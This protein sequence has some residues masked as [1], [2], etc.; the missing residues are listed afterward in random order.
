MQTWKSSALGTQIDGW[1]LLSLGTGRRS[2]ALV[3]SLSCSSGICLHVNNGHIQARAEA[4]CWCRDR[5]MYFTGKA[6]TRHLAACVSIY[7]NLR[8][9]TVWGCQGEMGPGSHTAAEQ[10]CSSYPAKITSVETSKENHNW[11]LLLCPVHP[12]G[13]KWNSPKT[14][15]LELKTSVRNFSQRTLGFFQSW[16]NL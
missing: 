16:V 14:L 7:P 15:I 6:N 3:T 13:I 5:R 1:T 12:H 10:S 4:E 9:S 8:S 11:F 2:S